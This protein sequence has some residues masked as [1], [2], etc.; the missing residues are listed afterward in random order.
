[1][2]ALPGIAALLRVVSIENLGPMEVYDIQ[3][4]SG[5]YLS[6]SLRVLRADV[7]PGGA[8]IRISGPSPD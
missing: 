2:S 5:E 4:E 8:D 3:T 7:T 1:M 6:G